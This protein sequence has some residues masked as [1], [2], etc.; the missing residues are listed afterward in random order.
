MWDTLLLQRG[1]L[2][3]ND[4]GSYQ[5]DLRVWTSELERIE[6]QY[7]SDLEAWDA[8]AQRVDHVNEQLY[9]ISQREV[10]SW[11]KAYDAYRRHTRALNAKVQLLKERYIAGDEEAV[12]EYCTMVLTNS[13]YP[14]SFPQNF[15]VDFEH[16]KSLLIVNYQLPSSDDIDF[17]ESASVVKSRRQIKE[18][19]LSKTQQKNMYAEIVKQVA[20]RTVHE[21][22]EADVVSVLNHIVFNGFVCAVDEA[23]GHDVTVCITSLQC[24]KD[25]FV[26]IDLARIDL[27]K[28]FEHLDGRGSAASFVGLGA[29]DKFAEASEASFVSARDVDMHL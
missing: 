7:A 19:Y 9:E 8:G 20:L 17:L 1:K 23:V 13:S 5:R 3:G 10:R 25:T 12:E 15:T 6:R 2:R 21:L 16:R 27:H 22:F 18:K 29:V 14:E 11:E 28:C 24:A 4:E 26:E